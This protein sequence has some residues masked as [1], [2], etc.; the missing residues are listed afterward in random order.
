MP[1]RHHSFA[2]AG[3]RRFFVMSCLSAAIL[4]GAACSKGAATDGAPAGSQGVSGATGGTG[5]GG[6]GGG[7][8]GRGGGGGGPVPVVTA[9]VATKAIPVTI[10]AVGSA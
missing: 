1:I 8:A 7:R 5:G 10:P 6:G 4:T 9:H 2:S 3:P